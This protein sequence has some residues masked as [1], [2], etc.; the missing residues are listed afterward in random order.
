MKAEQHGR[1]QKLQAPTSKL[2]GEKCLLFHH[3]CQQTQFH[4]KYFM[5]SGTGQCVFLWFLAFFILAR[6]IP[7]FPV[8]TSYLPHLRAFF[9]SSLSSQPCFLLYF[10][11]HTKTGPHVTTIQHAWHL[12]SRSSKNNPCQF[13]L[14]VQWRNL[15]LAKVPESP[16]S[17]GNY[18]R[19]SRMFWWSTVNQEILAEI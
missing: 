18:A 2:S 17:K 4:L 7:I 10:T 19:T 14:P 16:K 1:I 15:V 13:Y 9:L 3:Y 11:V 12:G 8:S 6:R 5:L